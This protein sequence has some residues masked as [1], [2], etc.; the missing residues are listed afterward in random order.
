MAVQL[1]H[2]SEPLLQ[3]CDLINILEV[4]LQKLSEPQNHLQSLWGQCLKPALFLKA[5]C[6]QKEVR[7]YRKAWENDLT[8]DLNYDCS[9]HSLEKVMVLVASFKS[10]SEIYG[11]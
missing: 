2:S 9:K 1:V 4:Q 7:L 10:S 6:L 11:I 5:S 3:Y 8:D